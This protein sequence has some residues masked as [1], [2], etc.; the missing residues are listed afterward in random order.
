MLRSFSNP[1]TLQNIPRVSA[2]AVAPL[3]A[4]LRLQSI[5]RPAPRSSTLQA[6]P[7][8]QPTR[9]VHLAS[10]SP[11]AAHLKFDAHNHASSF[12]RRLAKVE[13]S[14]KDVETSKL[15]AGG[16]VKV[17]GDI[18]ESIERLVDI[19]DYNTSILDHLEVGHVVEVR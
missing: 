9:N 8:R 4:L 5:R 11:T 10:D 12:R 16:K 6:T 13:Q 2:T 3:Q 18:I 15:L 1:G 14:L 17:T 19:D 7:L